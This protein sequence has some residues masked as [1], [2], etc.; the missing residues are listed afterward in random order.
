MNDQNTAKQ[1]HRSFRY[2]GTPGPWEPCKGHPPNDLFM[3][4]HRPASAGAGEEAQRERRWLYDTVKGLVE[5]DPDESTTAWNRALN[6]VLLS[7]ETRDKALSAPSPARE[8]RGHRFRWTLFSPWTDWM[9]CEGAHNDDEDGAAE[10]EHRP[11]AAS[12]E[13][14]EPPS[15]ELQEAARH[16]FAPPASDAQETK[17][18]RIVCTEEGE[19]ECVP[20]LHAG[21]NRASDPPASDAQGK[22]EWGTD[23]FAESYYEDAES[24][25]RRCGPSLASEGLVAHDIVSLLKVA[26]GAWHRKFPPASAP[27]RPA[28]DAQGCALCGLPASTQLHQGSE[29]RWSPLTYAH[30]FVASPPS[31]EK[32]AS[33]AQGSDPWESLR[34]HGWTQK[35]SICKKPLPSG[36]VL[37]HGE[38]CSH[39]IPRPTPASGKEKP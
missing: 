31:P 37:M 28:S 38:L 20:E 22:P 8:A 4:E 26:L 5:R 15:N 35:C 39:H 3:Y 32:P 6:E 1:E 13:R 23:E 21:E 30:R 12:A 24:I 27:E 25:V 36:W 7:I 10:S 33:D 9:P 19:H 34:S 11:A 29:I 17:G 2:D 18:L 14:K 16:T